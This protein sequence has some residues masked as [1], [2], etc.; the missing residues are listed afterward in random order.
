MKKV[1]AVVLA[2]SFVSV[3]TVAV[4]HAQAAPEA[5]PSPPPVGLG[6]GGHLGLAIPLVSIS[7]KTTGIGS[8]FVTIGISAGVTMKLTTHW[9]FDFEF[10]AYNEFKA[11]PAETS[12]VVDPGVLYNFGPVVVG[13]RVATKLGAGELTNVGI[14]PI[15][16]VPFK[17]TEH[18]SYFV[19]ADVPIFFTD[20]ETSASAT[21]CA[22]GTCPPTFK[23]AS[24]DVQASVGL[25]FQTGIAF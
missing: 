21:V 12:F 14:V 1:L 15:V 4:A 13:G 3:T 18:L 25:Q 11:T 20:N 19:E 5:A 22:G 24:G 10:V 16:V 2:F 7:S 9:A 8:D 17:I 23:P 6:L